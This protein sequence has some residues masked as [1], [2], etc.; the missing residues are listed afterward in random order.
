[1]NSK[2]PSNVDDH[3][4]HLKNYDSKIGIWNVRTLYR[5]GDTVQQAKVL[6]K[7]M[8]DITAVQEMHGT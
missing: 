6:K 5:V 2:L 7:Y 8:A 1:M 4:K 3:A